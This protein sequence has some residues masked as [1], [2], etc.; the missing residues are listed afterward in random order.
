[1]RQASF[2]FLLTA[3]LFLAACS[4]DTP[5]SDSRSPTDD[6]GEAF[7]FP[8]REIEIIAPAT[9]GG[10]WDA[11]ARSMQKILTDEGLID[12]NII[13]VNKPGG[14]GEVG[15]QYLKSKEDGHFIAI[16]SS[17][18]ITNHLLGQSELTYEHFTPLA[19][20]STE[21]IS[22]A[23]A[24]DSEFKSGVDIMEKLKADP[25]SLKIAV[26]P[27]LGNNDHLAFVQAAK[28][29]GVDVTQL[30]FMIYESGGD[31]VT[32]LLGGHVDVATMS[33]SE[34]KEQHLAGKLK[35]VAIGSDGPV[36]GL[37][38]VQTWTDQGIDLVFPH[39]RG[40]MGPPNMS[41]EEVVFW[42]ET[43]QQMTESEAWIE[44]LKN[45][46]W[47]PFYKNSSE[48]VVFLQEETTNY[49]QLIMDAGLAD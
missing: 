35:M 20:L 25:K 6:A 23:V 33:V 30:E 41:E 11:T 26:A 22:V 45:N 38:D 8:T 15:W 36:E 47:T 1:M 28:L 3:V 13:V 31:V 12:Q 4:S 44:L 46:E 43:F 19:I 24:P 34:A 37:E 40:V 7:N 16:N 29:Y 2:L 21:W 39:W 48:T 18:V 32:A 42:D 5:S 27:S 49:E 14:G 10:G 9:P 17:L